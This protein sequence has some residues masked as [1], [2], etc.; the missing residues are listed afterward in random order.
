MLTACV[1]NYWLSIIV[2]I[3]FILLLIFRNY[4]LY[5][6]RSIQR[7]EALGKTVIITIW[8]TSTYVARSPVYSHI[9]S[10]IQGLS[11]I[12]AYREQKRFLNNFHFYQNEHTKAWYIKVAC[13]RWFGMRL[14]IFGAIFIAA[15][16]FTS[17]PLSDGNMITQY[18]M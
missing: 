3:I 18:S 8:S 15:L 2:F 6:S 17:V 5:S 16:V 14:D 1:A 10:T 4:Y 11:T 12:R 13:N 9:S 7:L